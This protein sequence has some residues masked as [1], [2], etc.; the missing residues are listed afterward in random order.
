VRIL[1]LVRFCSASGIVWLLQVHSITM[2]AAIFTSHTCHPAN[3]MTTVTPTANKLIFWMMR[4]MMKS[5]RRRPPP[6]GWN[7]CTQISK[8]NCFKWWRSKYGE[9]T[10]F[11]PCVIQLYA[12]RMMSV[13]PCAHSCSASWRSIPPSIGTQCTAARVI[14]HGLVP[15]N[16]EM[17]RLLRTCHMKR[18][19]TAR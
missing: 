8:R 15:L 7:P 9:S 17:W 1:L 2:K 11:N 14:C 6:L 16:T 10:T 18:A 13:L 19:V 5:A 3:C 12:F 4:I